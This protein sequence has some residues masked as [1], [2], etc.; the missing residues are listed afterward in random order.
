MLVGAF[1]GAVTGATTNMLVQV[2]ANV[3]SGQSLQNAIENIDLASIGTAALSGAVTGAITGGVSSIS[4]IKNVVSLYKSA[5]AALNATANMAGTTVGTIIDN[6]THDKP[7]SENLIRNNLIAGAAGV[8]SATITQ[9]ASGIIVNQSGQKSVV[10]LETLDQTGA[11]TSLT[12]NQPI[13]T[14]V[15]NFLKE[16]AVSV[17]QESLSSM[18]DN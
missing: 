3:V 4:T 16:S 8:A 2:A 9:T 17:G 7:L 10:W 18:L 12:G 15:N 5:N 13:D 6:A 11:I 14:A 1:V